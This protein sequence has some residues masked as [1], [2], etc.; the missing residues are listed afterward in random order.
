MNNNTSDRKQHCGV[1]GKEVPSYDLLWVNDRYGIPYKKVCWDC[2][3]KTQ[4]EI[5]HF[6]FDPGYAGERLEGDY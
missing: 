2:Y 5:S 6:V 4:E 3:E 1:C